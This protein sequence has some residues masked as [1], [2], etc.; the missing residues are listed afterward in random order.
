MLLAAL[1]EPQAEPEERNGG[2]ES[3]NNR[4]PSS[5]QIVTEAVLEALFSP[6]PKLH[7]LVGTKWEGDRVIHALLEKLLDENDNPRHN[8]SRDE[9]ISLLDQHIAM[10]KL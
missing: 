2:E 6:K 4:K 3:E 7:Y 1:T 10:R 8:Y 9:L 5:P